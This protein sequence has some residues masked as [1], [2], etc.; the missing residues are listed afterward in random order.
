MKLR[1]TRLARL[2]GCSCKLRERELIGLLSQ[3]EEMPKEH[4]GMLLGPWDDAGAIKISD[5]IA[6]VTHLDF[7][8]PIVD[9]PYSYGRIAACNASSDVFAKGA[10]DRIGVLIIMG[11]PLKVPIETSRAI[12]KGVIDF[13]KEVDASIL[14]GH[15]IVNPWPIVGASVT[16]TASPARL[17]S[18]S[19]AQPGDSLILTKPLGVQ[20]VTA[21]LRVPRRM[22]SLMPEVS[23]D[24]VQK[25]ASLAEQFMMMPNKGAAE[26]MIDIGVNAA[27]DVTG[28]GLIGHAGIMARRSSVNIEIH[29]LPVFEGAIQISKTLGFGL[30]QGK[31]AETS[32]GLLISVPRDKTPMLAQSLTRK[33]IPAY[34]I[35]EAKSGEGRAYIRRDPKIVNIDSI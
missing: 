12:L 32:G 17:V 24:A 4:P 33:G 9:D 8:T 20:P 1:L 19:N 10:L 15:T 22:K 21:A 30:E 16:A 14:G 28:F 34:I 27:T 35:G 5:D 31:S 2:H 13:C 29:T 26:C 23:A 7:F 3:L 25:A 18:N 6:Y 11:F